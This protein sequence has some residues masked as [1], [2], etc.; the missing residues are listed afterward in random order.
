VDK[1]LYDSVTKAA[2]T[3]RAIDSDIATTRQSLDGIL[4][5]MADAPAA[6]LDKLRNERAQLQEAAELLP[7]KRTRAV[8]ALR[9]ALAAFAQ[10]GA[11][12]A[13]A[14]YVATVAEADVIGAEIAAYRAEREDA[15]MA[16]RRAAGDVHELIS[17]GRRFAQEAASATDADVLN[18]TAQAL[19]NFR[20]G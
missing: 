13:H 5:R 16:L 20:Q 10:A 8:A 17:I 9:E 7:I 1:K 11:Q 3:V 19:A 18:L 2:A 14:R 15:E 4:Q 12:D 6:G